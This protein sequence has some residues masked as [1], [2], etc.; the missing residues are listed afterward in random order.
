MMNFGSNPQLKPAREFW[1]YL[2]TDKWINEYGGS[3]R[4][5]VL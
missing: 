2:L 4:N 3:V 5:V 1:G